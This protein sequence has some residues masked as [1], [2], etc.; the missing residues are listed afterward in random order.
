M[1]TVARA[2]FEVCSRR[3]L[4]MGSNVVKE[5]GE[6]DTNRHITAESSARFVSPAL[7]GLRVE[8]ARWPAR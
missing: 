6:W 2:L 8:G 1:K 3:V 5:D 4:T 7:L